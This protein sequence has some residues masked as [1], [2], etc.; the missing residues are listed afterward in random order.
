MRVSPWAFYFQSPPDSSHISGMANNPDDPKKGPANPTD[1]RRRGLIGVG[2]LAPG[3]YYRRRQGHHQRLGGAKFAG[4]A[5]TAAARECRELTADKPRRLTPT[6]PF[7]ASRL[8]PYCEHGE[9]SR[10]SEK[11][12]QNSKIQ[13]APS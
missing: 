10:H 7:F 3:L 6:G 9:K 11:A 2:I 8:A 13:S 5:Q 12:R 1:R 4:I